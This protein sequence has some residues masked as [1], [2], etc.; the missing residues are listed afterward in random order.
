MAHSTS[1]ILKKVDKVHAGWLSQCRRG[2]PEAGIQ[3][4]VSAA[5]VIRIRLFLPGN[6]ATHYRGRLPKQRATYCHEQSDIL[7]GLHVLIGADCTWRPVHVAM[8]V[9]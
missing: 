5:L 4:K 6:M 7:W 8:R 9:T 3:G 1:S 2:T